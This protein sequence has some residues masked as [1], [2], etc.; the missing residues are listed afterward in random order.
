[1]DNRQ[2]RL[3]SFHRNVLLI[4]ALLIG[5]DISQQRISQSPGAWHSHDEGMVATLSKE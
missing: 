5:W 4:S 3:G 2:K 1:M